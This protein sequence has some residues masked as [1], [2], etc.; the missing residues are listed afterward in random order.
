MIC[1][2]HFKEPSL[3]KLLEFVKNILEFGKR[4]HFLNERL[5]IN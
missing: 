3:A 1:V 5:I 2:F 4:Y